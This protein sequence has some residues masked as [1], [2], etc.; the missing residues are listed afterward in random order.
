MTPLAPA[1]KLPALFPGFP[2]PVQQL[3]WPLVAVR[4]TE[5]VPGSPA[6]VEGW[7][8]FGRQGAQG[9][10]TAAGDLVAL[11]APPVAAAPP[12]E[13]QEHVRLALAERVRARAA[14]QLGPAAEAQAVVPQ[15]LRAPVPQGW[16]QTDQSFQLGSWRHLQERHQR[17]CSA[18]RVGKPLRALPGQVPVRAARELEE[19]KPVAPVWLDREHLWLVRLGERE[20]LSPVRPAEG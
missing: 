15:A 5:L 16:P 8:V 18:P 11:P 10:R 4:R 9:P 1:A 6:R 14:R 19:R 20:T 2:A 12:V 3:A 17:V 7:P 13:A